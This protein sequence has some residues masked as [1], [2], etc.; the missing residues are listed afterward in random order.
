MRSPTSLMKSHHH[1]L[2]SIRAHGQSEG[3]V[4]YHKDRISEIIL[5]HPKKRN[6]LS[7]KMIVEFIE[8]IDDLIHNSP[9]TIGV[10][11]RG[12]SFENPA[13]CAGL[14]FSLAKSVINT[15]E[16]GQ[17]MCS[18]MTDA[19]SQLK[20]SPIISLALI[21]GPALGGGA[22]LS[23]ACDFRAMTAAPSTE[24]GF[25]HATIGASPGWG[26]ATRLLNIVGRNKALH[27]LCSAQRLSP[28][29]AVQIGLC[30]HVIDLT[31]ESVVQ[32]SSSSPSSSSA[33]HNSDILSQ[34]GQALLSP[35][36][37]MTYPNA[38]K[39]LKSLIAEL[40]E[41]PTESQL[42]TEK[43]MFL[44]RWGSEENS[45]ALKKK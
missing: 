20:K 41:S 42:S 10:I 23:T 3:R 17:E 14:D 38:V 7:G 33:S 25:V 9:D 16:K 40:T 29:Q 43:K 19:L 39:D 34:H 4:H 5:D 22:E 1:F 24:I 32:S 13:F 35:Y 44:K 21:H 30:D 27:L 36:L 15:P 37:Q 31:D 11:L 8:I 45:S 12:K 6:A 26:G 2:N 18:L 28:L